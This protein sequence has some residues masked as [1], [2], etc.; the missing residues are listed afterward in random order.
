MEFYSLVK[1]DSE[2]LIADII[3]YENGE[4]SGYFY[5]YKQLHLFINWEDYL[6]FVQTAEG[7][8]YDKTKL[9]KEGIMEENDEQ[10]Q[11][12]RDILYSA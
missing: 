10:I 6:D 12:A 5:N 1:I 11:K 7:I 9:I 4:L 8:D 3:L 2:Q